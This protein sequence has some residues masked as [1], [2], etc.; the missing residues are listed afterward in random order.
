MENEDAFVLCFPAVAAI[1]T[2]VWTVVPL[3]REHMEAV[4][5]TQ[6]RRDRD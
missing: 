5:D 2:V 4:W 3:A 1:D 6:E